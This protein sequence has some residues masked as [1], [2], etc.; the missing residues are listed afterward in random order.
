MAYGGDLSHP[1]L[2]TVGNGVGTMIGTSVAAAGVTGAASKVWEANPTLN[3]LQVKDILLRSAIDLGAPGWDI[4]TGNGRL[5]LEGAIALAQQTEA[6]PYNPVPYLIPITWGGE[7]KVTPIERPASQASPYTNTVN[8]GLNPSSGMWGGTLNALNEKDYYTFT[9]NSQQTINLSFGLGNNASNTGVLIILHD[10][11]GKNLGRLD[12]KFMGPQVIGRLME[13][14]TYSIEVLANE[15]RAD[16][17]ST[18]TIS[19]GLT[20]V[21]Q[22]PQPKPDPEPKPDPG[23][24]IPIPIPIPVPIVVISDLFIPVYQANKVKLGKPISNSISL[25]NGV[26]QQQF[27]KGAIVNSDRGTFVIYGSI[28]IEIIKR[29]GV[30]NALGIPLKNAETLA[31]SNTS[32]VFDR[33]LLVIKNG[34]T[35]ILNSSRILDGYL[36][37]GGPSGWLGMPSSNIIDL[38]NGFLRQ[39]FENGYIVWNGESD[40]CYQNEIKATE[41]IQDKGYYSELT[42][43]NDTW[44]ETLEARNKEFGVA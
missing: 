24:G 18:Y 28:W 15:S 16:A 29:G 23:N 33:G 6:Q 34:S 14:G 1:V 43:V 40:I 4:L 12:S 25:G 42:Q 11:E 36:K 8:L 31:N 3:A 38:G 9:I 10:S 5:N 41:N 2:S 21:K 20:E 30:V 44:K 37:N 19:L 32:Q 27:E 26:T 17:S 22:D 13:P 39:S 35:Y 7:G